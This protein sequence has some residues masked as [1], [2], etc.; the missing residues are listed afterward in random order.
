MAALQANAG[1]ML[2]SSARFSS[3]FEGDGCA[4]AEISSS[5]SA[6]ISAGAE[7]SLF[8]DVPSGK[9]PCVIPAL[10]ESATIVGNLTSE[11][12]ASLSAQATFAAAVSSGFS[13]G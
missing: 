9:L 5:L 1:V 12:A 13:G 2:T 7:G 11:A 4:A 8:V 6:V 10:E 3:L